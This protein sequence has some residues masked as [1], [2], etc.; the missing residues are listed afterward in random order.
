MPDLMKSHDALQRAWEFVNSEADSGNSN[1]LDCQFS[2]CVGGPGA[3][4]EC[5]AEWPDDCWVLPVELEIEL[6]TR[7]PRRPKE[8]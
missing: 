2:K 6:P 4:H 7:D 3:I 5:Q 8:N 1:C